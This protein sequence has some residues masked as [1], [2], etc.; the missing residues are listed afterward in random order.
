[1][2]PQRRLLYA[3]Y[4]LSTHDH[5]FM[6]L[7]AQA[8]WRV[9]Y[10]RFDGGGGSL[11]DEPPPSGA[12]IENWLGSQ[13][14][15]NEDSQE[16]FVEAVIGIAE[17]VRPH[18]VHAGPLT[19][20]TPVI[21]RAGLRPLIGMSWASDLLLESP[22]SAR[23]RRAA[24]LS[25][26]ASSLVLVDARSV[27]VKAVEHGADPDLVSI[28]PW[29]VELDRFPLRP[30]RHPSGVL[31]LLSLRSHEPVYDIDTLLNGLSIAH[32]TRGPV[33]SLDIVG[34]G[35]L[36]PQLMR[37]AIELEVPH[38]VTWHGRVSERDVANHL[39]R[40]DV[41]VSTSHVDGTSISLLQAMA[42]GR[43]SIAVD[44]ASNREW[45]ERGATGW[46]FR[47]GDARDLADRLSEIVDTRDTLRELG[48]GAR[49]RVEQDGDWSINGLRV[50]DLYERLHNEK[51][52]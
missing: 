37:R 48:R 27:A 47:G 12:V 39:A 38:L 36:T 31:R 32:A 41:H 3:S 24:E 49:D 2:M 13:V 40:C 26:A 22:R 15:L 16:R 4:G 44:N 45:I 5:R 42:S 51:N 52:A 20:V 21:A 7:A 28:I 19:T 9:H 10:L 35:S 8:G 6:S 14:P 18:V 46:L 50:L 25:I 30:M 33:L 34:S 17:R 29:G 11:S 43:P 23:A 1:M